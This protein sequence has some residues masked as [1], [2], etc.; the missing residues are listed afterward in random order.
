[1]AGLRADQLFD[2]MDIM[3]QLADRTTVAV[4]RSLS[5]HLL[6]GLMDKGTGGGLVGEIEGCCLL[7]VKRSPS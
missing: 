3:T 6:I 5:D 1:M 4:S 2:D 7:F